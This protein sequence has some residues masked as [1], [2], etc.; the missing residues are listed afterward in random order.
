ME[1]ES[2]ESRSL[3]RRQFLGK[4]WW[5]A[6]GLLLLEAAGGLVASLWPRIKAGAF[7]SKVS[8]GSLEEVR[9]IPVGTVIYFPEARFYLSRVDSGLIALYRKC[10]HL[11]CVVPWRDDEQSEDG[12]AGGGR[13]NCPCH[14]SIFDRYG[15]VKGGP[16][17]RPLDLFPITLEQG[18]VKVD[19]GTIIE[20]AAFEPSQAITL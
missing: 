18:E 2:R 3:S 5:G 13:F 4:M 15:E 1:R 10:T 12:L 11:G 6:T 20:R 16:A 17:P 9:A 7:G 8:V 14:A 19:T